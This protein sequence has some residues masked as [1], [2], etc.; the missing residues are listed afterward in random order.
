VWPQEVETEAAARGLDGQRQ[1][2]LIAQAGVVLPRVGGILVM[3]GGAC[4]EF[5]GERAAALLERKLSRGEREIHGNASALGAASVTG[6][7]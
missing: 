1:E 5:G 4:G 2:A 6:T 7:G 3:P